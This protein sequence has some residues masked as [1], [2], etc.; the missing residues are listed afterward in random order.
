MAAAESP[1]VVELF[2]SQ[3][4]SSCPP[5]D[6]LLREL[7]RHEDVIPLGLHV[8][9]WDYI[10]WEDSFAQPVFTKRQKT[11]A[12]AAGERMV[13]TPQFVVG[14]EARI[15]GAKPMEVMEAV[16]QRLEMPPVVDLDLEAVAGS[17]QLRATASEPGP[18][19]VQLVRY[20]PGASVAIARGENAGHTLDYAN[21]VTSWEVLGHW[22]GEAA[23]KLDF[24][25]EGE[26]P[27]VVILQGEA[28]GEILAAAR[29]P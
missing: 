22:D 9:Y 26:A 4:C 23:L 18:M 16:M 25:V 15:V 5:A 17:M 1:V 11:Y 2:T 29:L 19:L 3:G 8:D 24:T 6:E 14:G 28:G 27:G 7:T 20:N 21:I 12:A 13:Y 10:G